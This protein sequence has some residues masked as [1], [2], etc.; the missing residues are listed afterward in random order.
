VRL[1]L[2]AVMSSRAGTLRSSWDRLPR[3]LSPAC[4]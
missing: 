1:P 3:T 4:R 2:G